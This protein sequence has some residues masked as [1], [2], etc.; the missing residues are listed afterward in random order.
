MIPYRCYRRGCESR[1]TRKHMPHYYV[2]GGPKCKACGHIMRA[3]LYRLRGLDASRKACGCG[4]APYPHRKGLCAQ[5]WYHGESVEDRKLRHALKQ[6]SSLT[7]LDRR[8]RA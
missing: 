3:D 5:G 6:S 8:R 4:A 7:T 2:A 1:A